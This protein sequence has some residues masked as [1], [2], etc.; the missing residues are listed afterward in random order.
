VPWSVRFWWPPVVPKSV[1]IGRQCSDSTRPDVLP[2]AIQW[3]FDLGDGENRAETLA[4][5]ALKGKF[6]A[7]NDGADVLMMVN[8]GIC[9]GDGGAAR[10]RR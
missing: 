3:L 2:R 9:G 4:A 5:S 7:W 8:K 1:E 10:M 6:A